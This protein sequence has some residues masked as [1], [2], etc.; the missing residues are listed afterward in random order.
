MVKRIAALAFLALLALA[1]ALPTTATAA[2]PS[3]PQAFGAAG[4]AW[5]AAPPTGHPAGAS[6]RYVTTSETVEAVLGWSDWDLLNGAW[7]VVDH[8]S[9][10]LISPF[11][12]SGRAHGK[13][14]LYASDGQT[15]EG[16][17]NSEISSTPECA[18]SD[19]GKWSL[20]SGSEQAHGTLSACLNFD[21]SY[22]TFVG[23]VTMAGKH[24]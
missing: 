6:G 11:G 17:Y 23:P 4:W 14:T 5:I 15:Y 13:F 16:S 12:Y 9:N 20:N 3:G 24:N 7:L 22:G 19:S 10:V 2:G 1:T 8:N 21:Y 18:I